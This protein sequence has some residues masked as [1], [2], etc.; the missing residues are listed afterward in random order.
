MAEY[1]STQVIK[2]TVFDLF[3]IVSLND[4]NGD[5]EFPPSLPDQYEPITIVDGWAMPD[6]DTSADY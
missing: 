3:D 5:L 1:L 6:R 4:A 2:S